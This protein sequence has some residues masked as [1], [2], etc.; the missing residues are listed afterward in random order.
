MPHLCSWSVI[1]HS[2]LALGVNASAPPIMDRKLSLDVLSLSLGFRGL[3]AA[4]AAGAEDGG[5]GFMA[6]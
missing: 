6:M 5:A 4:G 2:T 3:V 1:G